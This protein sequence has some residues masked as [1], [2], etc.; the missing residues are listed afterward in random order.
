MNFSKSMILL[1]RIPFLSEV[2]IWSKETIL[3][4]NFLKF[5]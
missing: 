3:K 1:H 5:N 2:N 4:F